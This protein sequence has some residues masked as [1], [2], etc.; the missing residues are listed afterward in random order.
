[1]ISNKTVSNN[2]LSEIH[3]SLGRFQRCFVPVGKEAGRANGIPLDLMTT[4]MHMSILATVSINLTL[5]LDFLPGAVFSRG[6][7]LL[8]FQVGAMIHRGV[9]VEIRCQ[10][11]PAVP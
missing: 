3:V 11:F 6:L 5:R 10:E 8:A 9:V 2:L 1:M 7:L 4:L